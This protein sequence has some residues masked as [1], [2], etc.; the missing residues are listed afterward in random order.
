MSHSQMISAHFCAIHL[1][2]KWI[3]VINR[4]AGACSSRRSRKTFHVCHTHT[5]KWWQKK[6]QCGQ[7]IRRQQRKKETSWNNCSSKRTKRVNSFEF[8]A[9]SVF[10]ADDFIGSECLF[11]NRVDTIYGQ[12]FQFRNQA[13]QPPNCR[14]FS[15]NLDETRKKV[16]CKITTQRSVKAVWLKQ[17]VLIKVTQVINKFNDTWNAF[18]SSIYRKFVMYNF[19]FHASLVYHLPVHSLSLSLSLSLAPYLFVLFSLSLYCQAYMD[20]FVVCM[21]NKRAYKILHLQFNKQ[22]LLN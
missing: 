8:A 9:V 10:F 19:L 1:I 17:R 14:C 13:D 15:K 16:D 3:G 18:Y 21:W 4:F 2:A 20:P 22:T 11:G 6:T 12:L 5:H 7:R